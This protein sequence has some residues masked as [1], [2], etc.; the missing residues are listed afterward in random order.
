MICG[1][2]KD[3]AALL[4]TVLAACGGTPPAPS[5]EPAS[6]AVV[7]EESPPAPLATVALAREPA[8]PP[9]PAPP[10]PPVAQAPGVASLAGLGEGPRA[11]QVEAV[12]KAASDV[13]WTPRFHDHLA[14]LSLRPTPDTPAIPGEDVYRAYVGL[15]LT[16]RPRATS[17]QPTCA[18]GRGPSCEVEVCEKKLLHRHSNQTASTDFPSATTF[19]NQCTLDRATADPAKD[20]E[21]FACAINTIAHEWTHVIPDS[22]GNEWFLD[23]GRNPSSGMLVSYTVGA[24]VECTWLEAGGYLPG[25]FEECVNAAGTNILKSLT[26]AKGWAK[27]PPRP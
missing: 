23:R 11:G 4:L 13:I 27:T 21:K 20:V 25:T 6:A 5:R 2:R 26:C 18:S 17:Y 3:G 12:I 10:P 1:L 14:A 9:P 19:L 15:D 7:P 22:A 24:V 16:R 8:S